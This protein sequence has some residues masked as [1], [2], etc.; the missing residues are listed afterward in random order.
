MNQHKERGTSIPTDLMSQ[1]AGA[2]MDA[3]AAARRGERVACATSLRKALKAVE[4]F[5]DE[6]EGTRVTETIQLSLLRTIPFAMTVG[7]KVVT[8]TTYSE[9][10]AAELGT[11]IHLLQSSDQ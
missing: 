1:V 11:A 7:G 8:L 10:E 9:V 2:A 6:C 5:H 3:I 4:R